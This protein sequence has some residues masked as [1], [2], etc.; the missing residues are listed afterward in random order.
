MNSNAHRLHAD[1][2]GKSQH[3]RE[4]KRNDQ[5]ASQCCLEKARQN[6]RDG[7]SCHRDEQ[8]WETESKSAPRRCTTDLFEAKTERLKKLRTNRHS[9]ATAG[10]ILSISCS[11]NFFGEQVR[12]DDSHHA[13]LFVHDWECEKF[14]KQKEIAHV[15]HR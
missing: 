12:I 1:A 11:Q 6:G 2:F 3:N 7:S 10:S 14:V 15:M 5:T 13:A 9:L 8:P 4:K